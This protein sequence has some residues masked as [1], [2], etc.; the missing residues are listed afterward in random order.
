MPV[1]LKGGQAMRKKVL[2]MLLTA[3]VF[4]ANISW[5][6]GTDPGRRDGCGN[7]NDGKYGN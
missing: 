2:A 3:T 1:R 5:G 4:A 6:G 7:G